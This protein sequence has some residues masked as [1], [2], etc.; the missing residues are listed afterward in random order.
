MSSFAGELIWPVGCQPLDWIATNAVHVCD[1][2]F[3]NRPRGKKLETGK[4]TL[5][6]IS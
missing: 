1:F 3:S 4:I 5:S 2:N 6:N